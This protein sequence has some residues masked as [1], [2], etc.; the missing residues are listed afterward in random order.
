L[1][2]GQIEQAAFL[3]YAAQI[4]AAFDFDRYDVSARPNG[5]NAATYL[6][7]LKQTTG[8]SVNPAIMREPR[9]F[10]AVIS[11]LEKWDVVPSPDAYY[12]EFED[13]RGFKLP[14]ERWAARGREIKEDFLA[15][16]GRRMAK[17][18]ADPAYAAAL[19]FVQDVN[20]GKVE[21]TDKTRAQM[22]ASLE[23][24][25]AAE[26]RMFPE[27]KP[28]PAGATPSDPPRATA[29]VAPVSPAPPRGPAAADADEVPLRV[30]GD[31]PTPK[32]IKHVDPVFPAGTRGGVIAEVRIDREGKVVDV[33]ILRADTGLAE[34][35]EDAIRQWVYEP[36]RVK[37]R[38]V[39]VLLPVSLP[40]R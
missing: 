14:R 17:L 9:Q 5:N 25:E 18:L 7:F 8:Q 26:A 3:F 13:A 40:A 32:K 23:A 10:A 4:R 39:S 30:G 21:M 6:A 1:R 24:M 11:R 2:Q 12:P 27:E 37:G 16:F 19:R 20:S 36:V 34:A 35:A 28:Q 33:L 31:V 29:P 22:E 38:P 15:Q